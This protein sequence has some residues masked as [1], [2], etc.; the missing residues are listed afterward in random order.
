MTWYRLMKWIPGEPE[1][2]KPRCLVCNK[3]GTISI[4]GYTKN[5]EK[6][7]VYAFKGLKQPGFYAY[8][9][10]EGYYMLLNVVAWMPLPKP[11]KEEDN[12]KN[13]PKAQ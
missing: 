6:L 9:S 4:A 2:D 3:Y 12:E 11:Y 13:I 8:D 10:D 5:L 7:N 1:V